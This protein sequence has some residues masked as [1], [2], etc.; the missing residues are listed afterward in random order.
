MI[1]TNLLRCE[2]GA[3]SSFAP[4]EILSEKNNNLPGVGG[5]A[6]PDEGY[7]DSRSPLGWGLPIPVD[8][9]PTEYDSL[10]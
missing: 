10:R 3:G 2:R 7:L 8:T 9:L 1:I 6:P 5:P 4:E